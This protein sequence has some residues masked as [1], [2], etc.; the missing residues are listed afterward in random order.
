MIKR[1]CIG[2]LAVTALFFLFSSFPA[3]SQNKS[4]LPG[5]LQ[6]L[7][8]ESVKAN[9]EVRQ[10]RAV[11]RAAKEAVSPAGA[12]DDPEA[13]FIIKDLPTD[14]WSFS[15]EDMTQKMFELTQKI[16]FPGKRRLRS[17]VAE[18]QAQADGLSYREKVNEIRAKVIVGYWG[19]ALA[20]T[21]F[22]ITQ[23]NK[24]FWEQV[25][26]VTETRYGVGQ[27]MQADVLQ[28][29]VELGT[30]LDRLFQWTQ[31]QE[32]IRGDLNALR[33]K[34]PQ[35]PLAQPQPLKPRAF[36]LKLDELLA[37]AEARPQL[38][39]LK[40]MVAKQGRAVDLAKKEYFPDF[41]LGVAYGLRENREDLKRSDMISSKF[42]IN[43]PIWQGSKIKPRIREEQA[44]QDASKD[45]YQATWNQMSAMIKDRHAKLKRLSQ[46]ITLYNQGIIPQAKQAAA[47]ALAAYAVGTLDFA[48]LYQNQIAAFNAELALQEYLKD[49]EENWAELEWL[50]GAELPR[51]PGG[52][53]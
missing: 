18:S 48:R 41:T 30:Y 50:V 17:E 5:D 26:Q 8:D 25:V 45:A 31:K 6:S 36:N 52:K 53:P 16:P 14:T 40:A 43:L 7:I 23:R 21:G 51:P 35:T 20:Y 33:S 32:S 9:S 46:Q 12:L 39:A 24:Q 44:K 47:S 4:N 38:H 11:H 3:Q 22:D 2:I 15:Q 37:R 28:A 42:M 34:P 27:G 29:Q 10:L 49:F 1:R 19:L 13:A